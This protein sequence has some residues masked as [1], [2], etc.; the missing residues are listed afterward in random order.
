MYSKAGS[1][2][3]DGRGFQGGFGVPPPMEVHNF[4]KTGDTAT[5]LFNPPEVCVGGIMDSES[6]L[7]SA[8]IPLSRVRALQPMP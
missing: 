8:V 5:S 4:R 2:S 6:A 3:S 7:R 1:R